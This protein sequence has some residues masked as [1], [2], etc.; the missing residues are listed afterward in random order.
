MI[1]PFC[2]LFVLLAL[3][4]VEVSVINR[5]V[6]GIYKRVHVNG[7]RGKSSVTQYIYAGLQTQQSV[8]A[9][10]TGEI[11]TLFLPSGKSEEI[12]RRSSARVQE[13]FKIIQ[14]AHKAEVDALVLECMSIDPKLQQLESRFYKPHIYVITNIKDDH[15]EKMG[16]TILEQVEAICSAIPKNCKVVTAATEWAEIIKKYTVKQQSEWLDLEQLTD[17]ER[18]SLP[19]NIFDVNIALALTVCVNLGVDRAVALKAILNRANVKTTPLLQIGENRWFLNAFPVNDIPSLELFL[20]RWLNKLQLQTEWVILL[21]TRMDRPT[22]T[23]LFTN[24]IIENKEHISGVILFGDHQERAVR[25]L[26]K[27]KSNIKIVKNSKAI[28]QKSAINDILATVSG[29]IFIGVGNIKEM[30][31]QIIDELTEAYGN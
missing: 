14:K 15:R 10:I 26:S 1:I 6:R 2:I 5:S 11:P 23:D 24:W 18:S 16:N 13:Q 28:A 22:R 29:K 20:D 9:K 19:E 21:N 4:I 3:L 27:V 30:G 31:Y 17:L 7:T 25:Q 12:N 8:M